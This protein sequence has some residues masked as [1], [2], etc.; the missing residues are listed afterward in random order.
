M[1]D[2]FTQGLCDLFVRSTRFVCSCVE[3]VGD[4]VLHLEI[5]HRKPG[6]RR[7]RST[8][9]LNPKPKSI[10]PIAACPERSRRADACVGLV[11]TQSGLLPCRRATISPFAAKLIVENDAHFARLSFVGQVAGF[12]GAPAAAC[13]GSRSC[14]WT[15]P[16]SPALSRPSSTRPAVR[17]WCSPKAWG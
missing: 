6:T 14:W 13:C 2:C 10:P 12:G 15:P 17:R 1:R 4:R 11:S 7:L 8:R 16:T 3:P 5:P 9:I